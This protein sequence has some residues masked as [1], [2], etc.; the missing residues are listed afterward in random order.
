MEVLSIALIAA[1]VWGV[2]SVVVGLVIGR[3][4]AVRDRLEAPRADELVMGGN[5][6]GRPPEI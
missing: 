6:P 1:T 5:E 4:I 3:M 2:V